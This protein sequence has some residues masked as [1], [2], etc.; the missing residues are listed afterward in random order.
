MKIDNKKTDK[1]LKQIDTIATKGR[2][3]ILEYYKLIDDIISKGDYGYL[4]STLYKYYNINFKNFTTVEDVKKNTWDIIILQTNSSILKKLKNIYDDSGVYQVGLEFYTTSNNTHL[5]K[6]E[7]IESYTQSSD[8]Y[9]RNK[10]YARIVGDSTTFLKV[11]RLNA[12]QSYLITDTIEFV[13]HDNI[14]INENLNLAHRY[15]LAMIYL[16]NL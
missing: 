9:V 8:Y 2:D 11:T 15:E 16:K 4:E 13:E 14:K 12:T 7:E 3:Y 10:K 1:I 5:G 6:V